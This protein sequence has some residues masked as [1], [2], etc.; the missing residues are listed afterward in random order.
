MPA[1]YTIGHNNFIDYDNF[2]CFSWI[3]NIFFYI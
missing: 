2:Y 1:G 3:S